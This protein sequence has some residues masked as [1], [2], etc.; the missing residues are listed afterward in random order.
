[1]RTLTLYSALLALL[2][3]GASPARAE[4]CRDWSTQDT[5]L[6]SVGTALILW[7]WD[8]TRKFASTPPRRETD[9]S[10]GVCV[11][12]TIPHEESNFL[13]SKRPSPQEINLKIG[14]GLLLFSA[15]SCFLPPSLR[16]VLQGFVIGVEGYAVYLNARWG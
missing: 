9:C 13:F 7:D 14:A 2:L 11:T 10:S 15:A 3:L 8:Q 4:L 6:Q 12:T 16:S 1:M 5:V